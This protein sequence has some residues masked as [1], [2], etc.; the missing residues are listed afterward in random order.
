M[1]TVDS[2]KKIAARGCVTFTIVTLIFYSIGS[3]VSD[4]EKSFIPNIKFIWLFF[5]FSVLLAAA[6]EIL[7]VKKIALGIRM[8]IHFAVCAALYFV[9][10]VLCG[11][12]ISSGAQTLIAMAMFVIVYLICAVFAAAVIN[13][14]EKKNSDSEEY[15]SQFR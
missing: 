12:F 10:V 5:A 3:I 9:C 15:R 4:S 1:K 7:S 14:R 2:I 11:G 8:L 13:R 6:N